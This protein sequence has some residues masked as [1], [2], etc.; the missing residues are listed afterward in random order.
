MYLHILWLNFD[1][2]WSTVLWLS[3]VE[4]LSALA[5]VRLSPGR[6][7]QSLHVELTSRLSSLLLSARRRLGAN[8]LAVAVAARY[9]L[10][11][12]QIEHSQHSILFD[13]VCVK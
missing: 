9:P 12:S 3:L 1:L 8:N 11:R 5:V 2:F 4:K 7:E 10:L 6:G 13:S